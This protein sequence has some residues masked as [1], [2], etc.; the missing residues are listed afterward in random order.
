MSNPLNNTMRR[1][2]RAQRRPAPG[3]NQH[4]ST[5][6]RPPRSRPRQ[7]SPPAPSEPTRPPP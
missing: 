7:T 3:A 5:H 4:I 6:P 2:R 1:R